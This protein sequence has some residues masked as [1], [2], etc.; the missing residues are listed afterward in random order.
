G[1]SA[2]GV[3]VTGPASFVTDGTRPLTLA[4]EAGDVNPQPTY[5]W[6][7]VNCENGPTGS[8][9]VLT[10][11][12]WQ[13]GKDVECRVTNAHTTTTTTVSAVYRLNL[14]YPPPSPPTLSGSIVQAGDIINC[15]V[16]GGKP[17]VSSVQFSCSNNTWPDQPDTTEGSTVTSSL[18]LVN[19]SEG[20]VRCQCSAKWEPQPE[21]YGTHKQD[22]IIIVMSSDKRQLHGGEP[23]EDNEPSPGAIVGIVIGLLLVIGLIALAVIMIMR[24]TREKRR[25][26]RGNSSPSLP[27]ELVNIEAPSQSCANG[28]QECR[29]VDSGDYT[30]VDEKAPLSKPGSSELAGAKDMDVQASPG[31]THTV[32]PYEDVDV[33]S[34]A[35]STDTSIASNGQ[36]AARRLEPA[37]QQVRGPEGD[38]DSQVNRKPVGGDGGFAGREDSAEQTSDTS[39]ASNGQ[40]TAGRPEPAA[41]QDRGPEG[42]LDSQ[43]NRKPVGGDGGFAG[44]EDS[45]EQ[46]SDT[47]IASNGQATAGRPEPAAQQDRG[48]EG[49]LDSQVNRK[50]V[51]GDGG[52]AGRE[53]SAEQTSDMNVD[54]SPEASHTVSPYEDVDVTSPAFSTDT[55]IAN[56][57]QATARRLEPAAQQGRGQNKKRAGGEGGF[58][59][60]EAGAEKTSD[61]SIASNGQAT[62][63]RPE[64]AAQQVRGPEGDLDSQVN[65]KPVG[66]DGGF[67]GR[68]DSAEQ[69]SDK[70]VDAS[71]EASHT[72]SPYED[73]DVTGPAFSTDTSI[74]N[75]GQA[76]ARRLEPAAQQ[77]RGPNKK[78]AGGGGGLALLEAGAVETSDTS[79]ASNGQA[80]ARRPEPAAQQVRGPEGDLDSQVNRKPVGGDGGFAGREDSAEQTSAF[81]TDTSIASNGQAAAR[82]LEPAAQQVRGPE[83]DLD[84]QVN[85]KPVGGD[86]GF[87]GREDSAEQ[88]SAFSTDTSIASNG[89]AAARRLEPAA[90]QVRGPN[91][92]PGGG[93]G[94]FAVREDGAEQTSGSA[95]V[96]DVPGLP[97][98]GGENARQGNTQDGDEEDGTY[99]KLCHDRP[100]PT[101]HSVP[102]QVYSHIN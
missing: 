88:T 81:S 14:S 33:T 86:G 38:L 13:D 46:T 41:Q 68:E 99:D 17:P 55:S 75:N 58:A 47:S 80:A 79:I 49:D 42:D 2:D 53:D 7:G 65:R 12:H 73:V 9:C 57:G 16:T 15:T 43:V 60:L 90:Q 37:A 59:L 100:T 76:T 71:P 23:Q 56:N 95:N 72:V 64:P 39:I 50:P 21:L 6:R 69:T 18:V 40:A 8:A 102:E 26:C 35:F 78:R 32:S 30:L 45:A 98:A 54:A 31:A 93:E 85:R 29:P 27:N 10:P 24:K 74:A 4:C 94:G 70:N 3:R 19:A 66:G 96:A 82:R 67:A 51:G 61:T 34:P 1:P 97:N 28:P 48:P 89:Q 84:S 25:K 92:K 91:K 52:F 5:T 11:K 22:S 77:V 83:G 87:A 20:E 44:R 62:A 63:R 36:A 101:T